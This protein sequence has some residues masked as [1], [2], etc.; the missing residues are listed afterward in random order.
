M[1]ALVSSSPA[2]SIVLLAFIVAKVAMPKLSLSWIVL[3]FA[4][5]EAE[6][7][8]A[9]PSS[10]LRGSPPTPLEHN[11]VLSNT[12]ATSR[13][14]VAEGELD[15]LDVNAS[16]IAFDRDMSISNITS[17]ENASISEVNL[18]RWWYCNRW[19]CSFKRCGGC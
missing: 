10:H 1:G 9:M 19:Y 4:L 11:V 15:M 6:D 18:T 17:M 12:S 16:Q 14:T 5:V 3:S 8:G 7:I 13:D 2:A